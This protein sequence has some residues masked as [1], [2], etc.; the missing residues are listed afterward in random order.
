MKHHYS[1]SKFTDCRFKITNILFLQICC[2]LNHLNISVSSNVADY[3][4]TLSTNAGVANSNGIVFSSSNIVPQTMLNVPFSQSVSQPILNNP[5]SVSN[6]VGAMSS[7]SSTSVN[8]GLDFTSNSS[9]FNPPSSQLQRPERPQSS[10]SSSGFT[11]APLIAASSINQQAI[12]S[13]PNYQ[14]HVNQVN[15]VISSKPSHFVPTSKPSNKCG[16]SKYT[17]SLRVVGGAISQIGISF[18]FN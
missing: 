2:S 3:G 13:T 11:F 5:N 6:V 15:P 10:F 12:N 7:Q 8:N 1:I 9:P 4:S 14:N 17:T 16:I 18:T